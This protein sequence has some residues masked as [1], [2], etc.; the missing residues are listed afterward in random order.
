MPLDLLLGLRIAIDTFWY[1][2]LLSL[3]ALHWGLL[4][5]FVMM[6]YIVEVI[7]RWLAQNAFSP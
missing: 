3:A 6:G 2:L 1:N 4:R 7:N 5:G